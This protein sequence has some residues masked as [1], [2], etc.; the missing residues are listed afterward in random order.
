MT[1][2]FQPGASGKTALSNAR[3]VSRF[4]SIG[5]GVVLIALAGLVIW[6]TTST[7]QAAQLAKTAVLLSDDY[8]TAARCVDLEES[9]ERLYRIS[10]TASVFAAHSRAITTTL[11]ALERIRSDGDADDRR[12]VS[13]A[14][15][16]HGA[17]EDAATVMFAAVDAGDSALVA[18]LST[19]NVNPAFAVI[20]R[21]VDRRLI[22]EHSRAITA[23]EK[24]MQTQDTVQSTTVAGLALGMS[25]LVAFLLILRDYRRREDQAVAGE[26]A[27]LAEDSLTDSLTQIGNR[28]SFQESIKQAIIEAAD[29]RES[30]VLALIDVD[31]FK[32][33]N[34]DHGH[35]YGDRVLSILGQLLSSVRVEDRKRA[36]RIGG[37]EF[38][39]ILPRVDVRSATAIMERLRERFAREQLG[40]TL[41]VGVAA[42]ADGCR[43]A[44]ILHNLAD[45][46][47]YEA[48]RRGR[49]TV[50]TLD[51]AEEPLETLSSGRIKSLHALLSERRVDIVFQPICDLLG[52]RLLG[53]EALT[54]PDE[55]YG[56]KG[57]QEAFDVARRLGHV[58][59]LDAVCR[60]AILA[61]ASEVPDDALLFINV[62]PT[63]L[64]REVLSGTSLA[65]ALS[66]RGIPPCRVVLEVTERSICRPTAVIREA[67]RLRALGF[68]LALDDV[69]MGN[70]GLEMLSRLAVDFVKIDRLV[71]T[72]ALT[73]RATRAVL[74]GI[75]AI[76]RENE[77]YV[78]AEGIEDETALELVVSMDQRSVGSRGVDGVQGYPLGRPARSMNLSEETGREQIR[79]VSGGS[80][81]GAAGGACNGRRR[82]A[83]VLARRYRLPRRAVFQRERSVFAL[84]SPSGG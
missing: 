56:F 18:A 42:L 63:T 1:R 15:T 19:K 65:S 52:R 14:V 3:R 24:L 10:P 58:H 40:A 43:D 8:Q 69:G 57:T 5:F 44:S 71:V 34:D 47:L 35:S 60:D 55:K 39:M 28:R 82:A 2:L 6:A 83:L 7:R 33:V 27:R 23:L 75:I 38:A 20:R 51:E 66:K 37:D 70:G 45:A 11:R 76:A 49:N 16:A 61:R 31:A 30:L 77:S 79:A 13:V 41:S 32:L 78:I 54:R 72:N 48:K 22:E 64:E 21:D 67:K 25:C 50:A 74:A 17:Y 81:A 12:V 9:L 4:V 59:E 62:S 29:R 73:D 84:S 36:Y 53:Y 80:M 46:A 68:L 26:L